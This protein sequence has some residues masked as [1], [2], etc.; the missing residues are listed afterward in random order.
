[1]S[2][3]GLVSVVLNM[4]AIVANRRWTKNVVPQH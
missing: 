3:V 1:M 2:Q 4:D